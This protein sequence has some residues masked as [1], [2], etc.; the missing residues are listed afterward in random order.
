MIAQ[1]YYNDGYKYEAIVKENKL[2][3]PDQIEVGQVLQIPK[4][5]GVT[6]PQPSPTEAATIQPSPTAEPEKVPSDAAPGTKGAPDITITQQD[7]GPKITGT[8]YT[9]V[10]GDWLSKIAGRA[11]EDIYA[12]DRIA[13]ANNITNPD[14]IFP[15]MVLTIPR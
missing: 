11:Y 14:L 8:T 9:V 7:W 15:G 5:E 6:T 1:K 4:L 12:Y 13:K 3:N 10:E 2:S